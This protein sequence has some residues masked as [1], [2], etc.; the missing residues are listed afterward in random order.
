MSLWLELPEKTEL[1]IS[2]SRIYNVNFWRND[3]MGHKHEE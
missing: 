1:K 3:V 2:I